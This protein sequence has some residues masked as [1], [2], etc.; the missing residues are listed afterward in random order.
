MQKIKR[1]AL[2]LYSKLF[3]WDKKQVILIISSGRTGTN[4]MAHWFSELSDEIYSVHEPSPDLFQIG[5]DKYRSKK[6]ISIKFLK[7]NRALQLYKLNKSHKNVYI[8][9]NPNLILLLP[10]LNSLFKNIKIIFIKREFETYLLSAINKSPDKSNKNY[11][12]SETDPRK[13]ITAIDFNDE[14]YKEKWKTLFR[15]E[16][17]AWWWKKSNEVIDEYN[18]EYSNSIIVDYE[19]LFNKNNENTLKKIL[20]FVGLQHL[21][22]SQANLEYFRVKK[23][24]NKIKLVDDFMEIDENLRERLNKIKINR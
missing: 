1:I 6:E 9:S 23:N 20:K 10:E 19:I 2:I 3:S 7:I 16:K 12:Y 15:E 11:F 5:I 4:F 24:E 8:E 14:D 18:T 17:I 13:R 21:K 22:L